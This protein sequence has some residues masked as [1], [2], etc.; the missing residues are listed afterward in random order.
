MLSRWIPAAG[1]QRGLLARLG[2]R[3]YSCRRV[4][5]AAVRDGE[6]RVFVVADLHY[7]E[8]L[9]AVK[10]G[11]PLCSLCLD[12]KELMCK[13]GLQSLFPMEEIAIMGLWELLPHIYNV[14][15]KIKD[16]LDAAILFR[17]HAVVT[18]DSKGFSF[19]LL[20]QLKCRYNQKV[21]RPLHVHY[22]APSF[23]AWKGGESRLSKLHNF[24]DHML[25]I[26]PFED[27]ICRLHGLPATYVGHPLLD[28]AAV[29][30]VA[31][32]SLQHKNVDSEL[33][34][35]MSTR[36]RSGE[37]FR[38]EH[39]LSPDAT[40]LTMLPGSRMQEVARMLPIFFRTVQHLSHTLNDL[41]LVIPVA[42]HR[43]VRTYVE[44]VVRSVP[45]PVVLIPGGS[46][47]K[48]YGAFNASKAALCT[49]GTAVM[50]LM[51][52]KLPCVVA[53]QAH[54]LTECFIHLRKKINF[55]SLPNI[56][57]D[58]PIVP[59][60]LFRA[61]TDKNLAAKL[62][63][64]IF[65]DEVR[66]LQVGSAERMLQVLYEPIKRR[67]NLFAE[68]SGDLGLSSDVYSPGT[69]AALTVLYMDKN[70]HRN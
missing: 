52:A 50:E 64:V 28:D 68:E 40:I 38:L 17:P 29:L 39:G 63:E 46:L 3:A 36:Q 69:I 59:E 6:L 22:V 26:L 30:N 7:T 60:I 47:E 14:K 70:R 62:S 45:F 10:S 13:E 12:A 34:P 33:S 54:F 20:Q 15:R 25:C 9:H 8:M 66:Q 65:N 35:D 5:D 18:V 55:I 27:E 49:S 21:D 51:L 1:R 31:G 42:P 41:S 67:G 24:V 61:C 2:S 32:T 23:W 53:Y 48:R 16:T 19:R 57:L 43:D 37:A 58:S 4:F 56:L 44:N 11:I